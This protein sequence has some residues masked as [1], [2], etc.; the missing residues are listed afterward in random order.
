MITQDFQLNT[1]K[2]Q[3]L[4]WQV[5]YNICPICFTKWAVLFLSEKKA[6]DYADNI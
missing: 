2:K 3:V 6:S 1:G 4:A 5:F